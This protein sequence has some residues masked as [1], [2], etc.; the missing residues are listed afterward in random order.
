MVA[1]YSRRA[2]ARVGAFYCAI[3]ALHILA[4]AGYMATF[5]LYL[6]SVLPDSVHA[7]T[8]T[9]IVLMSTLEFESVL[10][11]LTGQF[12]DRRGR[13]TAV[14]GFAACYFIAFLAIGTTSWTQTSLPTVTIT[15]FVCAQ[16]VFMLG[17]SLMSGSLEAWIVDELTA[18]GAE[19]EVPG[20][21][22]RAGWL[23]QPHVAPRWLHSL[24]PPST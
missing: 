14:L 18:R 7:G 17:S 24:M 13:R 23:F 19:G 12:A 15:V 1:E 6:Q 22:A 4:Q 21:F 3:R 20:L 8:I 16:L 9:M 5:A 10:E 11:P 2:A